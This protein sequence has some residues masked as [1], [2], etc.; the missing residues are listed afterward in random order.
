MFMSPSVQSIAYDLVDLDERRKVGAM[1]APQPLDLLDHPYANRNKLAAQH[2]G[3]AVLA[4]GEIVEK[5]GPQRAQLVQ[6][7]N[8]LARFRAAGLGLHQHGDDAVERVRL[9]RPHRT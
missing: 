8:A 2:L 3:Q 5:D 1:P 7:I 9:L 4:T 6:R